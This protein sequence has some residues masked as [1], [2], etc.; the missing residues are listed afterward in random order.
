MKRIITVDDFGISP[1]TNAAIRKL[2]SLGV[3]DRVAVMP[4]GTISPDD[5]RFLLDSGIRIDIHLDRNAEILPERKLSDGFFVRTASFL[6]KYRSESSAK[7][8]RSVWEEQLRMFRELFGKTPDG[9]NSHEHVHFFP[10]YFPI[11]LDIAKRHG[12][13][14][15]RFGRRRSDSFRLV[16]LALDILRFLNRNRFQVSGLE[17]SDYLVSADWI[18]GFDIIRH[19]ESFPEDV[20]IEYIFHP[21]RDEEFRYLEKYAS[22]RK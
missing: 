13:G 18:P 8:V 20:S 9:L 11:L 1:E 4:H 3:V 5:I 15:I 22:L 17:T 6:G 16:A 2:I 10:P 7:K 12:I 19:G 21:E 14:H